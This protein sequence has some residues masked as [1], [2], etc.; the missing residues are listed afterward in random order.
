MPTSLWGFNNFF[1]NSFSKWILFFYRFLF[2]YHRLSISWRTKWAKWGTETYVVSWY[3]IHFLLKSDSPCVIIKTSLDTRFRNSK[4]RAFKFWQGRI[5]CI[6]RPQWFDWKNLMP[7]LI[8]FPKTTC[9]DNA[10][11]EAHGKW[12]FCWLPK[13]LLERE[14]T[15]LWI[16]CSIDCLSKLI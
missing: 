14:S 16:Q 3:K 7:L 11:I 4:R 15:V 8:V 2:E 5:H 6:F 12:N 10:F 13:V 9:N 1:F